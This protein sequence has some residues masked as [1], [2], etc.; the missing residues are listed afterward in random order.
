MIRYIIFTLFC[1]RIVFSVYAVDIH[2]KD[3]LL[4]KLVHTTEPSQRIRIYRNLADVCFESPDEKIYL[5]K[6]YHE[7]RQAGDKASMV[8][9]LTDITYIV[10]DN[11]QMDS[12]SHYIN[13]IKKVGGPETITALPAYI[14]MRHF[15]V[16]YYEG[17]A[18][19]AIDNESDFLKDNSQDKQDVY[20]K[21]AKAYITG[22]GLRSNGMM[23]EALPYLK[24]AYELS[25][26]ISDVYNK[27]M[28]KN[29][30]SWRLSNTYGQIGKRD[31]AT[32]ILEEYLHDQLRYYDTYYKQRPYYNIATRKLQIYSM[33]LTNNVLDN[34][35][36]AHKYW[37]K[38]VALSKELTSLSDRYN[39]YLSMSNYYISQKP[40]PNY[41][42]A[43]LAND[44]LIKFA[45]DIAPN[46]MPGLYNIESRIYEEMGKYKEALEYLRFSYKSKDSLT[47]NEMLKQLS[48]L[49]VKYDINKLNN[50]KSH[51][52]I[53]NKRILLVFLSIILA[54]FIIVCLYL[55]YSLRKERNMKI[56]LQR[57][58]RKAMESENMKTAFINSICHEIRTPLNAIVGFSDLILN[59]DIDE[60]TRKEFPKEIQGNTNLL[61]SLI[62]SMLEVSSLD[63]SKE[64]LPCVLTDIN[65]ICQH[66]MELLTKIRK[67]DVR[68]QLDL[69]Q[70]S[71]IIPTHEKY[72]SL[73]IEHLLNNANKFTEKGS[74]TLCCQL[75]TECRK[76]LIS[77]SDTGCGI[78]K[79]K[80]EEVFE[81]FSK[82][83][84]FVQ[85]NGLGLYLCQLIIN[86]LSGN[87]Y[88]D[89]SYNT[90]T[91]V[92]VTL[93]I[94]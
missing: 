65:S 87:I 20:N 42:K 25:Q 24:T 35:Q 33:I 9:A 55:F 94:S 70:E 68:Y 5:L 12:I 90:G 81:R 71:I 78:P 27:Y 1:L 69:S 17:K 88:I 91:R 38:I 6:M 64:K 63:V 86:R 30:V 85:G 46:N 40:K 75:D 32:C 16:L 43:L 77:V 50:E 51:L 29:T 21:I 53:K 52:E 66:E 60:E 19:E 22:S 2:I 80:Y 45:P 89:P 61:I 39:Y 59:E 11:A 49:Q 36:K 44:S 82:L 93:P 58:N 62:N 47:N 34:P 79:D 18:A 72:L 56:S 23:K 67:P 73:V 28:F 14:H 8:N 26:S 54:I 13:L 74:I 31:S 76:L 84:T 7:A 92:I 10:T 37:L 83:N 15:D 3:S 41:E 4:R 57:L 48:E